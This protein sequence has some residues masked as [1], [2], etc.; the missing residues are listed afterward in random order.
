LLASSKFGQNQTT[1]T[2]ALHAFVHANL[3]ELTKCLSQKDVLK[4]NFSDINDMYV[5]L[6]AFSFAKPCCF[7]GKTNVSERAELFR[8]LL[9]V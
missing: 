1:V 5:L 6:P 4:Q 3:E 7:T 2:G 9:S 8:I